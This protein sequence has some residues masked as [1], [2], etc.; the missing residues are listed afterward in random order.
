MPSLSV[1]QGRPSRRRK[2]MPALSSPPNATEPSSR[3]STNHLKPT[4]TSK[5]GRPSAAAMR[6]WRLEETSVLPMAARS[7]IAGATE[8]V[9]GCGGQDVVGVRAAR[10]L[11]SR[12]R[13]GRHRHRCPGPRRSRRAC[14]MSR[15]MACGDDGS[16]RILPSQS[17][18]MKPKRGSMT[19]VGDR[20]VEAG[21]DPRWR[22]SRRAPRRPA[23]RP[24]CAGPTR[25]WPPCR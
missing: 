14:A 21:V 1:D 22:S 16:M 10:H 5:S 18:V 3:P 20:E 2:D 24:R 25:R 12:R 15:A 8:E 4:G 19:V 11:A 6:S 23:G 9:P 7:P 13:S 17:R